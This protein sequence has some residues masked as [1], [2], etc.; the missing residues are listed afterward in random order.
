[1][2]KIRQS[3]LRLQQ[4]LEREPTAAEIASDMDISE[5]KV[6]ETLKS[7]QHT[8]SMDAP[9]AGD[10]SE[11]SL[12]NVLESTHASRTDNSLIKE[13]LQDEINRTLETLTE[14]EAQVLTLN[15]GLNDQRAMSL[16]E[17]GE[18]IDLSRERVRQIR[19]KAI[20]RLRHQSKSKI[21]MTYL[22]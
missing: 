17:I 16:S 10:E 12:H 19:E 18:L 13:S 9:L 5:A 20:K 6:A 7:A 11:F 4:R 8:S 14:K 3:R 1:M 15:Y 21:L 22:G 2:S